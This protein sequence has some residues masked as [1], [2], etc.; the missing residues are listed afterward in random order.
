MASSHGIVTQQEP[1]LTN[2]QAGLDGLNTCTQ[3]AR[4]ISDQ[5]PAKKSTAGPELQNTF[6]SSAKVI[7]L[8]PSAVQCLVEPHTVTDAQNVQFYYATIAYHVGLNALLGLPHPG[9]TS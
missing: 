1:I 7:S 2:D 9:P 4:V 5:F 6:P 3:T 8:R